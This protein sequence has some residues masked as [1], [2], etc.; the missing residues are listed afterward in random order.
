[1]GPGLT[2]PRS[3]I[4]LATTRRGGRERQLTPIRKY[5]RSG[6]WTRALEGGGNPHDLVIV[7]SVALREL[8]RLRCGFDEIPHQADRL[9]VRDATTAT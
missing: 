7:V 6:W 2:P 3:S 4:R 9:I 8:E 5:Q 1:M